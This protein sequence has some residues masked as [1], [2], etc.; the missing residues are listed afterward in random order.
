MVSSKGRTGLYVGITSF[1]GKISLTFLFLLLTL[2]AF[3]AG[4]TC[5]SGAN[6]TNPANPTGSLVTLSSLGVTSCYYVSA[7]GSDTNNG[8]SESSPFL[9]SPGMKNCSSNCASV[10]LAAGIGIIFRGGDT[11]HFG[12]SNATPYAGTVS[13]CSINQTIP[14]GWCLSYNYVA[15]G[16]SSHPVYVGVDPTWYSGGSW[17][18]PALSADNSFCNGSTV[19]TLPDGATCT[20]ANSSTYY[21]GGQT[22][23]NQSG[24]YVSSCPYQVTSSNNLIDLTQ[25][26]YY[27]LD[28]FEMYGICLNQVGQ[29]FG[30]NNYIRYGSASGPLTFQNLY[31]HG[32]SHVQFAGRNSTSACTGSNVCVD[33]A[34]FLGS[35]PGAPPGENVLLNVV[36]FSD[37][38]PGGQGLNYGGFYNVAYNVFR[39]L[40]NS[41]DGT[42][43]LWHDNLYE[44][45][46]EDGHSNVMETND[47][48]GANAIYNNVFRHIE[49]SVT[50]G[51]GVGLWFGPAT[52][53][54]DY[55][56]NNLM[57]DVGNFEYLNVG[58][59]AL[60][61]V[62]GNYV[63]FNN[64]W[65]TNNAQPILRCNT[66][67][68]GTVLD[69]NT[70][71]IDDQ[72]YLLAACPTITT[73]T[74][75]AQTNAQAAA[76]VSTHFDQYT[77][78]ET[79]GYSPVASTNS[80]VG[81]GTK[82]YSGYCSALST[83][84]LSAAAT[85]CQSD[86]TYACSYAGNGAPPV[87]P[88]R[89]ATAR[90]T[91]AAWDIGAYAYGA[92]PNPPTGLTAVVN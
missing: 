45:F 35:A 13:N 80:T 60:T 51:G 54:T 82:E 52:G 92:S 26:E 44:Y 81:A 23:Y 21:S 87:C 89:T 71:Y 88:A 43:H 66:Y 69:T 32:A 22:Y 76:N 27:I 58:G 91:S 1:K 90:P 86:I 62:E 33:I 67:T 31:I 18:R 24:Y 50:S 47:L 79:H 10:S 12:N 37:S 59:D 65:Q 48:S 15:E 9:H 49:T 68:N 16:T 28:N 77:A 4:G 11:W 78:S 63:Y 85:A 29:P 72:N 73:T 3:G 70:H 6:Y 19:G 17:V 53:A 74:P 46:F 34:A 25:Q 56:F 8:I 5:P 38:D 7:N 2:P 75:L 40:N 64:T 57:Y 20:S 36:D 84:G 14:A 30:N 41:I 83:A 39:Y 55:I 42:L 61:T